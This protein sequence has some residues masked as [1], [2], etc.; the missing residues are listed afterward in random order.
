M[1]EFTFNFNKKRE[2][3]A[4]MKKFREQRADV[5]R[6]EQLARQKVLGLIGTL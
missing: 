3:A 2:V 4:E 6:Y 1:D 5:S